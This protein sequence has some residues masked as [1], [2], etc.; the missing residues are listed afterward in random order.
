M[1]RPRCLAALRALA[2]AV[3]LPLL[4]GGC[5]AA[6]VGVTAASVKVAAGVVKVPVKVGATVL[7]A[8]VGDD[9]ESPKKDAPCR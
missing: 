8:A 6:A 3:L 9:E 5:V 7:G 4:T 2:A 1:A